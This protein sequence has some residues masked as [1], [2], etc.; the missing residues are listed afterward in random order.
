[1]LLLSQPLKHVSMPLVLK[2]LPPFGSSPKKRGTAMMSR[3][4]DNPLSVLLYS[5][6][7]KQTSSTASGTLL[8]GGDTGCSRRNKR[9][10]LSTRQ[11]GEYPVGDGDT[12]DD[13]DSDSDD[14]GEDDES[15]SQSS[16]EY[17]DQ[18]SS[19]GT[20]R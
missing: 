1:M 9:E 14:S 16:D 8:M 12:S 4:R 11:Y 7:E 17:E 20:H 2:K 15:Q 3:L 13:S 19:C 6:R 10:P 18:P 5:P